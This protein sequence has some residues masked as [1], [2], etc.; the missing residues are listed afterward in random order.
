MGFDYDDDDDDEEVGSLQ[1]IVSKF[2]KRKCAF[3]NSSSVMRRKFGAVINV[4]TISKPHTCQH[5]KFIFNLKLK[6]EKKNS[7]SRSLFK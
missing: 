1:R 6:K 3:E 2:K 7:G 4:C 5:V